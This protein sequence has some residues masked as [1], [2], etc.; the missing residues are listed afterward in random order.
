MVHQ[1]W[2]RLTGDLSWLSSPFPPATPCMDSLTSCKSDQ[3]RTAL[4][5]LWYVPTHRPVMVYCGGKVASHGI[6]FSGGSQWHWDDKSDLTFSAGDS[7]HT[8]H[9]SWEPFSATELVNFSSRPAWAPWDFV[10]EREK[11]EERKE[12][13]K[14]RKEKKRKK[15]ESLFVWLKVTTVV[16]YVYSD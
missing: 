8:C 12:E 2:I 13:R 15:K 5:F 11:R 7:A 4:L 1:S 14:K 10:Q 6:P 16:V 9:L 3:E